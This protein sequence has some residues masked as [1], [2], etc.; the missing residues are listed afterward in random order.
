MCGDPVAQTDLSELYKG[1]RIAK[2]DQLI[3]VLHIWDYRVRKDVDRKD[4]DRILRYS[5][6]LVPEIVTIAE[7]NETD[8]ELRA[9]AA[10]ILVNFILVFDKIIDSGDIPPAQ[11][12]RIRKKAVEGLLLCFSYP[13]SIRGKLIIAKAAKEF[14]ET[15]DVK[16]LREAVINDELMKSRI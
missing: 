10:G 13:I 6:N 4:F 2:G 14:K 9:I 1:L 11:I 8:M 16:A 12:D 7:N 15:D 5:V 3:D